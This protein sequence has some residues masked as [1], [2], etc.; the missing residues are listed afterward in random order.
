MSHRAIT[1][2]I[3]FTKP[4]YE[5]VL[6]NVSKEQYEN[7][8][9]FIRKCIREYVHTKEAFASGEGLYL[10][11]PQAVREK[12][13][14]LVRYREYNTVEEFIRSALKHIADNEFEKRLTK[15]RKLLKIARSEVTYLEERRAKL[16]ELKQ[17]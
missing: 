2:S 7:I 14:L 12:I 13:D 16:K 11:I 4:E 8:S 9:D 17:P 1:I 15:T 3:R 10:S 6:K 5:E